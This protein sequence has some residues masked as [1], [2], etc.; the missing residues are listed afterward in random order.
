MI[1]HSHELPLD[2][3]T[4]APHHITLHHILISPPL[5]FGCAHTL[6]HHIL[7]STPP[8]HYITFS[9]AAPSII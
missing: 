7:I 9:L 1:P 6:L 2:I 3:L 8:F 5:K 4:W